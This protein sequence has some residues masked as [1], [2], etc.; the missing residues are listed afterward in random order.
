MNMNILMV[1]MG[2]KLEITLKRIEM[3]DGKISG[4]VNKQW[5]KLIH[6]ILELKE[7]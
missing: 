1:I 3:V 7:F 2:Y 6:M 5:I 4:T